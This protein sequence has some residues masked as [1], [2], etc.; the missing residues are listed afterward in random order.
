M[1]GEREKGGKIH[2]L[3]KDW[4]YKEMEMGLDPLKDKKKAQSQKRTRKLSC[5]RSQDRKLFVG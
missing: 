4:Q 5:P 3:G 1:Y 2:N